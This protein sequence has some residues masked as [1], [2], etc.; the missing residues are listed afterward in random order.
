MADDKQFTSGGPAGAEAGASLTPAEALALAGRAR[1]AAARPVPL[2][3]WYGPGVGA[4]FA[5][6]GAA[7]GQS[8]QHQ[9]LWLIPLCALGLVLL[10]A[11]I[12]R[13]AVRA[14]GVARLVEGGASEQALRT[15]GPI[16]LAAALAG[17]GAWLATGDQGWAISA[18]GAAGGLAHWV[19]IARFNRHLSTAA[20]RSRA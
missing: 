8:Y 4:A 16:V 19:V 12:L 2:P 13:A 9:V 3:W 1:T 7:I 6:Y 10:V 17:L 11:P 15:L 20:A 14:G 18:A 5:A